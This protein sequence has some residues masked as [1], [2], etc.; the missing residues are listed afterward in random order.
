MSLT[1]IRNA[2]GRRGAGRGAGP[3]RTAAAAALACAAVLL[4]GCS[5]SSAPSSSGAPAPTGTATAGAS[6]SASSSAPAGADAV[7]IKNFA[8]APAALTVAPGAKVTVMNQDSVTHTLTA[9]GTKAFDTGDIAAG[10]TATF[11][12]PTKPGSYPYICTIHT[13]M[14][15]TL[16]VS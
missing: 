7:T 2:G 14:H 9:T 8:F 6:P 11:T 12:A 16:T 10:S 1:A 15:G 13:Y 5:S 4:A 3:R